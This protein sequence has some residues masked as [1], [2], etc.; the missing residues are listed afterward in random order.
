MYDCGI[1][2]YIW[3]HLDPIAFFTAQL[4]PHSWSPFSDYVYSIPNQTIVLS[5][6]LSLIVFV[7][8]IYRSNVGFTYELIAKL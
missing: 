4:T 7:S 1:Y 6:K 3:L 8:Q 2:M 5:G